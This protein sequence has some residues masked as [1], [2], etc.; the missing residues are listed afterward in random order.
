[1]TTLTPR[2]QLQLQVDIYRDLVTQG[3]RDIKHYEGLLATEV[4]AATSLACAKAR[5]VTYELVANKLQ[6]ILDDWTEEEDD[7]K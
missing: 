3:E 5:K 7:G 2:E 6:E 4:W 1:M